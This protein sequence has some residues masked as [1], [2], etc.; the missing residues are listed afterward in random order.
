M[1]AHLKYFLILLFK[2]YECTSFIV[3][4]F[5]IIK[6]TTINEIWIKKTHANA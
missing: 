4:I 6:K 1:N 3:L 5:I 2:E